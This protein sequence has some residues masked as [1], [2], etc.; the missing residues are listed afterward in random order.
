MRFSD[1]EWGAGFSQ[2]AAEDINLDGNGQSK[3]ASH[4]PTGA[5]SCDLNYLQSKENVRSGQV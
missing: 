1:G 4:E 5:V 3:L 2:R